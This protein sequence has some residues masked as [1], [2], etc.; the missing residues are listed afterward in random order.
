MHAHDVGYAAR[1]G[2]RVVAELFRAPPLGKA[3]IC[4]R[5]PIQKSRDAA[6]IIN[7]AARKQP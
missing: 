2:Y 3:C 6:A 4:L 7:I 1:L 5:R